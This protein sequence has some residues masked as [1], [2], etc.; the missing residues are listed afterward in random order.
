M[1]TLNKVDPLEVSRYS[2]I[3]L[4]A[5]AEQIGTDPLLYSLEIDNRNNADAAVYAKIWNTASVTVGTT[6]PDFIW[7]TPAGTKEVLGFISDGVPGHVFDFSGS[8]KL[9]IAAVTTGGKT[10]TVSPTNTVK[11]DLATDG[12]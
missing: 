7:R 2:D 10:G 5:T 6:E 4:D 11:A 8:E 1:G 9:W 3:L 12:T